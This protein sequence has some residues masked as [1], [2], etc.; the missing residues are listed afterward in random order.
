MTRTIGK[1]E[2][3]LT[4]AQKHAFDVLIEAITSHD[5]RRYWG[6]TGDEIT[7]GDPHAYGSWNPGRT[8]RNT[9]TITDPIDLNVG[10]RIRTVSRGEWANESEEIIEWSTDK[11]ELITRAGAATSK[12]ELIDG[13]WH[14]TEFAK[15]TNWLRGA[16]GRDRNAIDPVKVAF[17]T[18]TDSET[19]EF[20]TGDSQF[21]TR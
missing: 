11:T 18:M 4:G 9:V 2:T 20:S 7:Y 16:Y 1:P 8:V 17:V 19:F 6:A 12:Y 15:D 21:E 14:R 5:H 3:T 10:D 13:A